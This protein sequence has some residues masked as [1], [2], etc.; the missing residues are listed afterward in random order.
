L[1]H[2][3]F[4]KSGGGGFNKRLHDSVYATRIHSMAVELPLYH[5]D[6]GVFP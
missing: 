4:R 5:G 3:V 6:L 1:V 2:S